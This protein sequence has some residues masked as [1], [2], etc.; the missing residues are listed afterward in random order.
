MKKKFSLSIKSILLQVFLACFI[1]LVSCD[2]KKIPNKEM[3]SARQSIQKAEDVNANK[4]AEEMFQKARDTLI[5]THSYMAKNKMKDAKA[6]AILAEQYADAAFNKSLPFAVEDR[7]SQAEKWM[8]KVN[9]MFAEKITPDE[10]MEAISTHDRANQLLESKS[11]NDALIMYTTVIEMA[12]GIADKIAGI[13]IKEFLGLYSL[14]Q[15]IEKA[16]EYEIDKYAPNLFQEGI[17][18]KEKAEENVEQKKYKAAYE[19]IQKG[20]E[21]INEA[22]K[23]GLEK[24]AKEK[25][26]EAEKV[27]EEVD[28]VHK[29]TK[30]LL[31]EVSGFL[32]SSK[33]EKI[34]TNSDTGMF[35]EKLEKHTGMYVQEANDEVTIVFVS[36]SEEKTSSQQTLRQYYAQ[37]EDATEKEDAT[38]EEVE[39]VE[40]E[41]EEVV[42]EVVEEDVLEAEEDSAGEED[43]LEAE[44]DSVEEDA[45]EAEEGAVEEDALEAE[46]DSVEEDAL[47]AEEGY[48]RRGCP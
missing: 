24:R 7:K 48:C 25:Y 43:A 18:L 32:N 21:K 20:K 5:S 30:I 14:I 27:V 28:G 38:T 10:Y 22:L 2:R 12:K 1:I 13:D 16:K 26:A 36:Q 31:E 41:V 8:E 40:L 46:E 23:I 17:S 3:V 4:Y 19:E 15:L 45:L 11:L 47:E 42:E 29:N 6:A 44:E 37:T 35:I 39:E 34:K 33:K 9:N